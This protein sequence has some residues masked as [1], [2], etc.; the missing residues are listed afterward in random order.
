MEEL[1][2]RPGHFDMSEEEA[3]DRV[4]KAARR[5]WGRTCLEE[6]EVDVDKMDE[7]T[8]S[9]S[10]SP[11]SDVGLNEVWADFISLRRRLLSEVKAHGAESLSPHFFPIHWLDRLCPWHIEATPGGDV[12]NNGG[13]VVFGR[14]FEPPAGWERVVPPSVTW[15]RLHEPEGRGANAISVKNRE[16]W[17]QMLERI[18]PLALL[19]LNGRRHRLMVPPALERPIEEII[20]EGVSVRFDPDFEWPTLRDDATRSSEA[21]ELAKWAGRASFICDLTSVE[22]APSDAA[23]LTPWEFRR[24]A[25]LPMFYKNYGEM[26]FIAD[27]KLII[28]WSDWVVRS[29]L[30]SSE[31]SPASS[32]DTH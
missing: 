2:S 6:I 16:G 20:N 28:D 24:S 7:A 23:L 17:L 8:A 19:M 1:G 27:L 18:G 10:T 9:F 22:I 11:F 21:L 3:W 30:L 29:D 32:G 31:S 14:K 26:K 15:G 5:I 4:D 12:G 13:A 25:L